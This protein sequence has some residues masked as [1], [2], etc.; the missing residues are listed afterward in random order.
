VEFRPAAHH[1]VPRARARWRRS[2]RV[3]TGTG[4]RSDLGTLEC[5]ALD[6]LTGQACLRVTGV[7]SLTGQRI[8]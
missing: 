7:P 8:Y 1:R 6:C 3:W 2:S 5:I 4:N